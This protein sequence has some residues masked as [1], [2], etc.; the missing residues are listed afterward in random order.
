M[1]NERLDEE[2]AGVEPSRRTFIKRVA[3]GAAFATP[4]VSSFSMSGL[5]MNAASAQASNQSGFSGNQVR[6]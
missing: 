6:N 3:I 5:T 4:I 1:D 2:L